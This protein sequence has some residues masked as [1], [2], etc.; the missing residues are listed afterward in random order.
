MKYQF[1]QNGTSYEVN[2]V[3]DGV[4]LLMATCDARK[5]AEA[6]TELL[7]NAKSP[8]TGY[9]VEQYAVNFY[10]TAGVLGKIREIGLE[11]GDH[12]GLG[13]DSFVMEM[14]PYGKVLN[15]IWSTKWEEQNFPGVFLYEVVEALAAD[16]WVELSE[17]EN[18]ERD[19]PSVTTFK[20]RAITLVDTWIAN[21]NG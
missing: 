5:D 4:K 2:R 17:K 18:G 15:D 6:I 11:P 8:Y 1:E 19:F 21:G 14:M 10:I 3:D 12:F 20:E 9:D 16:L 7:N 13:E